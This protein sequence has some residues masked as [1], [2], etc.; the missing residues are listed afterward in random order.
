M[1]RA[2]GGGGG[3]EAC[4]ITC[5]F[6]VLQMKG[7]APK[8]RRHVHKRGQTRTIGWLWTWVSVHVERCEGV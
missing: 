5:Y 8:T 7:V 1:Y 6:V 4:L 3:D 2:G